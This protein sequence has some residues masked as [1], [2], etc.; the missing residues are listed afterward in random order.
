[1]NMICP[2]STAVLIH[3]C[4]CTC[5]SPCVGYI[6]QPLV[7]INSSPS[8]LWYI[9]TKRASIRWLMLVSNV[10]GSIPKCTL[11]K[12]KIAT[13]KSHSFW[14][15]PPLCPQLSEIACPSRFLLYPQS[16]LCTIQKI[17]NIVQKVAP[18]VD[19]SFVVGDV[20]FTS[21][22]QPLSTY[23]LLNPSLFI[24]FCWDETFETWR[25]Q[26][27]SCGQTPPN[28]L[29]V[30]HTRGQKT[31]LVGTAIISLML[32]WLNKIAGNYTSPWG[33]APVMHWQID[34]VMEVKSP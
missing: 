34:E 13:I 31:W 14:Q 18:N 19:Q 26:R 6:C 10:D 4:L 23:Q 29:E 5:A 24:E 17:T 15:V 11:V 2:V 22:F 1:M 20:C 3:L 33:M 32:T 12:I 27:H 30:Y 28:H 21:C 25:H 16:W 7:W 8:S 9:Q